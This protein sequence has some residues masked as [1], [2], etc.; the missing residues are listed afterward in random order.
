MKHLILTLI[1]VLSFA[2]TPLSKAST[3]AC[4][5]ELSEAYQLI[6]QDRILAFESANQL[7][8]AYENSEDLCLAEALQILGRLEQHRANWLV[9]TNYLLDARKI[10]EKRGDGLAQAKTNIALAK[11]KSW[12]GKLDSAYYYLEKTA[13]ALG[14]D[15]ASNKAL[16]E[17]GQ[18][19]NALA[20][21]GKKSKDRFET[22]EE[23]FMKADAIFDKISDAY[24]LN[25][26]R[27]EH[28]SFYYME[29]KYEKGEELIEQAY[30][31]FDETEN[32]YYKSK[33]A[34]LQ[35]AM[36]YGMA[37]ESEQEE[38]EKSLL[39]LAEKKYRES[40]KYA[41][42]LQDTLLQFDASLNL[43]LIEYW[44]ATNDQEYQ[45]ALIFAD[46]AKALIGEKGSKKDKLN[47]AL[48]YASVLEEMEGRDEATLIEYLWQV[49]DLK[50]EVYTA[51]V[52]KENTKLQLK[53]SAIEKL[54]LEQDLVRKNFILTFVLVL[55]AI[56]S[57]WRYSFHR[58]WQ[59]QN[60]LIMS[61]KELRHRNELAQ[62]EAELAKKGA[63][64]ANA[65]MVGRID[66]RKK[67]AE[68]LHDRTGSQLAAMK[69][70][71]E[72][73]FGKEFDIEAETQTIQATL[74]LISE[75]HRGLSTVIKDLKRSKYDWIKSIE[76]FCELISDGKTIETKVY[77]FQIDKLDDG[78]LIRDVHDIVLQLAANTIMHAEANK[79][80]INISYDSKDHELS[81]IVE[82]D[83]KGFV[84]EGP[85]KRTGNGLTNLER[86]VRKHRGTMTIDTKPGRGTSVDVAIPVNY[87]IVD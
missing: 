8:I 56:L 37:T 25:I 10:Y 29:E 28:A 27:Y 87:Q 64:A 61:E 3:L 70:K 18:Y 26:N 12:E 81:I 31:Y 20:V 69:W 65:G 17:V 40:I 75:T 76:N 36:A 82:D 59:K 46:S 47:L 68:L 50:D 2:L 63:E 30:A 39:I 62:K 86:K 53:Q 48:L 1:T 41:A 85:E 4:Q 43:G 13:V 67:I 42:S 51:E 77:T 14:D 74:D 52:A 7:K 72:T 21:I 58:Q 19:Y 66:E 73:R 15:L 71:L 16:P 11:L 33:V 84:Y 78:A 32:Y 6:H 44:K 60:L 38:D 83:G 49:V 80:E 23:H 9:A 22:V 54:K 45:E 34:N 24:Y 55:L 57:V 35:G 5:E 79:L